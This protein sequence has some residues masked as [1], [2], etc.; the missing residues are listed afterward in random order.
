MDYTSTI[1][2]Q[3]AIRA[4]NGVSLS[5]DAGSSKAIAVGERYRDNAIIAW[6]KVDSGGSTNGNDFGVEL[7]E[8]IGT[9]HYAITITAQTD[10]AELLIPMVV[11]AE[12][13]EYPTWPVPIV[14]VIQISARRF[15]VL[16]HGLEVSAGADLFSMD[17]AFVFMVT[18][19]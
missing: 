7:V 5:V 8:R 3:F 15:D 6:A 13:E 12:V 10:G 18:G 17:Q 1:S 4:S 2:N 11:A 14:G 9:G 19:R 16:V